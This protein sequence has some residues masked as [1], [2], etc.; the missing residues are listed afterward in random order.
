MVELGPL[1]LTAPEDED[2]PSE[3]L[4]LWSSARQRIDTGYTIAS[5]DREA[6]EEILR[7]LDGIPLAIEL[8]A[9]RANLMS[10]AQLRDRLGRR[11]DVLRQR[12][13][14]RS[15]RRATME[16]ALDW[17]WELLEPSERDALAQCSV[18]RASFSL[19]AAEA[20][21]DLGAHPDAP[22]VLDV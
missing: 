17:S 20:V 12:S 9:A 22:P 15:E 16:G 1:E 19:D 13:R 21:I 8:A 5:D 3:A 6:L 2:R 7:R 14:D 4:L 18:F 10:T 11:F